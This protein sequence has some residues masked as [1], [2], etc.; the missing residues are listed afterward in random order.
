MHLCKIVFNFVRINLFC[1]MKD[2]KI[3][4]I[5]KQVIGEN[6][7]YFAVWLGV[8]LVPF[9]NA[10]MM[11]EQI[12]PDMMF[13]AW[14]K[15]MPFYLLFVTNNFLLFKYLHRKYLYWAYY[16]VALLLIGG[17]FSLL[18]LYEQSDVAFTISLGEVGDAVRTLQH[19]SLSV[20]PWWGNMLAAVAMFAANNTIIT[21]YRTMREEV[22]A[23]RLQSQNLQAEMYYLKHQINPHFLMN[24]LNNIHALVDIDSEA[25][26]QAVIQLS[27]MMRHVVYGTGDDAIALKK[28]LTFIENYI[29]LMRIRYTDD[30]EIVYNRPERL[31]GNI[32]IPPLIFIVFVENAFKHG[33]S[34]DSA[35]HIHIDI[36]YEK[37][38]VV[39][40]FENSV[41]PNKRSGN[42]GIGLENVRKRLDLIYNNHY[43]LQIDESDKNYCITLKI[44]TLNS[45]EM[46]RDR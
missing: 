30:V 21:F 5:R 43:N 37:G 2:K 39:G 23:E 38:F 15:I 46:H 36:S 1:E 42:P 14:L 13:V 17:M 35:S 18:E 3:L 31:S 27:D 22:D 4:K 6:T 32:E 9:M 24:T 40:R 25:A 16:L 8:F 10:G 12:R 28:D 34:Y 11:S 26:K 20:F 7:L 29:E 41:H 44:P 33:V 19:T 45:Y